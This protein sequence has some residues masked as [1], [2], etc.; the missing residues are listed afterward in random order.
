MVKN[1]LVTEIISKEMIGA[2]KYLLEELDLKNS[3]I[4]SFFWFYFLEEKTW[5]LIVASSLVKKEG[6]RSFYKRINDINTKLE[7]TDKETVSL[8]NISVVI[9]ENE[10]VKLL[11]LVIQTDNGISDIRF[12]GN[13]VNG[14]YIEDVYIYRSNV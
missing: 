1:A 4:K 5:K 13:T 12:T 9:L 8:H 14:T 6:P 3:Q 10:I 7:Q 2:G 11:A